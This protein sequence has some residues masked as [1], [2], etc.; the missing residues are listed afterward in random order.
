MEVGESKDT[1]KLMLLTTTQSTII[2]DDFDGSNGS[3]KENTIHRS[4]SKTRVGS[5]R[6]LSAPFQPSPTSADHLIPLVVNS[7]NNSS[8]V[9]LLQSKISSDVSYQNFRFQPLEKL[10]QLKFDKVY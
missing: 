8:N 6:V 5:S 1:I 4:E 3:K 2:I 10:N 9:A 7:N